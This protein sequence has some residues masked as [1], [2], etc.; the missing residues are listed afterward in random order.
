MGKY[1]DDIMQGLNEAVE[2]EKGALSAKTTKVTI[3][4]VPDFSSSEVKGIRKELNATQAVFASVMGVSTKTV[5]AWE[6]G[7]N[8]PNGTARRLLALFCEKPE[9]YKSLQI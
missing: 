4:K 6:A 2:Y 1:F 7:T 9:I 5:E 3:K 8:T